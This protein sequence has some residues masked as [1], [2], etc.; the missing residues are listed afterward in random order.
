M[1]QFKQNVIA[2]NENQSAAL[3]GTIDQ[4]VLGILAGKG[5]GYAA[6]VRKQ[7]N[8]DLRNKEISIT[9]AYLRVTHN[10]S[11]G[12]DAAGNILVLTNHSNAKNLSLYNALVFYRTLDTGTNWVVGLWV[13]D[14]EYTTPNIASSVEKFF[15]NRVYGNK[16][17]LMMILCPNISLGAATKEAYSYSGTAV[18]DKRAEMEI[19]FNITEIPPALN[20]SDM[21]VVNTRPMSRHQPN[22]SGDIAG[23]YHS[24]YP[25]AKAGV[26]RAGIARA[27]VPYYR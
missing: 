25:T 9:S 22:Y 8:I 2:N 14:T 13:K 12:F 24:P 17:W 26:A 20:F 4:T 19:N 7:P 6:C 18:A 16:D 27:G 10:D 5:F 15:N 1:S 11:L 23:V 21:A 3:D